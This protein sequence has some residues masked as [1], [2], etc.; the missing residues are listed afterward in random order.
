MGFGF[1]FSLSPQGTIT[2]PAPPTAVPANTTLPAITGTPQSGSTLTTTF[3]VWTQSPDGYTY[4]WKAAGTNIAGATSRTLVLTDTE[5]GKVIT[6][7]VA[8]TN[9]FGSVTATSTATSAVTA[10]PVTVKPA[11]TVAPAI[12]GTPLVGSTLMTSNGTWANSPASYGYQW[13]KNSTA[14]SGAT[15]NIFALVAE[16]FGSSFYARVT[17]TNVVGS[18]DAFTQ[19]VG[20]VG[21]NAPANTVAPTI[22][23]T[24][25]VTQTLTGTTGTWTNSPTFTYQWLR[26][27]AAI[28]DATATT[29]ALVQAD[30]DATITFRVTAS[31]LGGT[32]SAT[33]TGVG[34]ITQPAQFIKI[35]AEGDSITAGALA[36]D[37]DTMAYPQVAV[38]TLTAGPTYELANIATGGYT[39]GN[40]I[41]DFDN[42]GGAA[43][44][45]TKDLNVFT[46]MIGANDRSQQNSDQYTYVT[47]RR[48][49]T[50]ARRKGYSRRIIGTIIASDEGDAPYRS[51]DVADV[52]FNTWV[53]AY[54]TSDLDT[55][56]LFD[57]GSDTRFDTAADASDT[58]YYASDRTH[59]TDTGYAALAAIYKPV[60]QGAIN[61]PGTRTTL[62]ATWFAPDM[63]KQMGLKSSDRT[64]YWPADGFTNACVRGAIGKSQGKW[65]FET[66]HKVGNDPTTGVGLMNIDFAEHLEQDWIDPGQDQNAIGYISNEGY[67]RYQGT[68]LAF[69]GTILDGDVIATAFDAD[70]RRVWFKRNNGL[71]NGGAAEGS[72]AFDPATGV[73]GID[74]SALGTEMLYPVGYI[75]NYGSEITSRFAVGETTLAIPTGF[76]VIGA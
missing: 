17:A 29:Y 28:T 4:Q 38:S 8:A 9:S 70:T 5:I 50:A 62:P 73:G 35:V 55:D 15:A 42:R 36:T 53:K 10:K 26:N 46:F 20:P 68:N 19:S 44:D 21:Q 1:S 18:T 48:V 67:I 12:T 22:S 56:G 23:G 30:K 32:T 40:I 7:T 14:I 61:G 71:W 49:L 47:L 31:N 43:Y 54:A 37:P 63:S 3:G 57:F 34:P 69:M 39:S 41:D 45:E 72:P 2:P 58:T 27:G 16:D 25:Q 74:I 24:T 60:L 13:F 75:L 76:S 6:V 51:W 64:V 65:Y 59:L 52:Q 66:Q 33:A 11:N